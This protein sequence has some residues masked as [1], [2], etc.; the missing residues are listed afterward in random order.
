MSQ[1]RKFDEV[2]DQEED[3]DVNEETEEEERNPFSKR[4][5]H[6]LDSDEEDDEEEFNEKYNVLEEDIEGEEEGGLRTEEDI[7]ITPF[8]MKEELEEGHVDKDG[9]FIFK[10][11]RE[12]IKDFWL[13]N[14]D[15]VKIVERKEEKEGEKQNEDQE[16]EPFDPMKCYQQIVSLMNPGETVANA[17]KRLGKNTKSDNKRQGQQRKRLEKN[18]ESKE[19]SKETEASS[20]TK[21]S[22]S[23]SSS[24]APDPSRERMLSLISLAD[25]AVSSGDMDVYDRSYEELQFKLKQESQKSKKIIDEDV[26]DIFG[27]EEKKPEKK[28]ENTGFTSAAVSWEFK[29]EDKESAPI[30]G[31]F[32]NEQM[33][34][35]AEEGYFDKNAVVVRQV[36]KEGATFNSIKRIDFDLYS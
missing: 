31:P 13:D 22:T 34:Q 12:E 2:H 29:W 28:T 1:R 4:F 14:I 32:S 16:E 19:K 25:Q 18:Q 5:K 3:Q 33:N 9:M 7:K 15:N 8:N 36:M 30:Y 20:S 6:T 26:L 17:I 24:H 23:H 11:R 27:E 21:A 35:W 10:D